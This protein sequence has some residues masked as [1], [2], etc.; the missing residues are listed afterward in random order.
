MVNEVKTL[1][2]QGPS[3]AH[4]E[5]VGEPG[6]ERMSPGSAIVWETKKTGAWSPEDLGRLDLL[7]G[8]RTRRCIGKG[9]S[10]TSQSDDRTT[11]KLFITQEG[12]V[13]N[14][15]SCYSVAQAL[16]RMC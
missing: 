3:G 8:A 10:T 7:E 12:G 16:E 13:R 2:S 6:K 14:P 1:Q 15:N 4:N 11:A 5:S 9:S